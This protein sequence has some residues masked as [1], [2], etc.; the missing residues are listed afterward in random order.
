MKRVGLQELP[1]TL[2]R[3]M[4]PMGFKIS[5]WWPTIGLIVF[6]LILI[7]SIVV[8]WPFSVTTRGRIIIRSG[9]S[10]F[11]WGCQNS[12][13]VITDYGYVCHYDFCDKNGTEP[14]FGDDASLEWQS[15][16]LLLRMYD[17]QKEVGDQDLARI[18]ELITSIEQ[19]L[20]VNSLVGDA[21]GISILDNVI[22]HDAGYSYFTVW[23]YNT[24][25]KI[26]VNK[27]T[28]D[29]ETNAKIDELK[30]LVRKY[31]SD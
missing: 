4:K 26:D 20:P 13:K 24:D 22:K 27:I 30:E 11:A 28:S 6:L 12:G 25:K 7:V 31:S 16:G 21:Y 17:C 18:K 29:L 10:S 9:Y 23:D 8:L 14:Q 5:R 1:N 19:D 2:P 3:A 15:F